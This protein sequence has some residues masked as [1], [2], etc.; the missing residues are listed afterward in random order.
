M[1]DVDISV[2]QSGHV[3]LPRTVLT[4]R[5]GE[6]T[7]LT[8]VSGSGKTSLLKA[9]I[10][11]VPERSEVIGEVSVESSEWRDVNPLELS[12]CELSLIHI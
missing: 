9:L 7:V 1:I 5:A 6:I 12:S 4:A 10:G 3:I 11:A 8:G 2:M